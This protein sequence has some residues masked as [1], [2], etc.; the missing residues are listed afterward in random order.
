M[1]N[2]QRISK[3]NTAVAYHADG[4]VRSVTLHNTVIFQQTEPD[5]D[6]VRIIAIDNGGYNSVT[7]QTRLNQIFNELGLPLNYSRS[8]GVGTIHQQSSGFCWTLGHGGV[9]LRVPRSRLD[10]ITSE[11]D[12]KFVV[13]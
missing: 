1:A 2:M 3:N 5:A 4:S 8:G 6:G 11:T 7:T 12:A 10:M 9:W 13:F